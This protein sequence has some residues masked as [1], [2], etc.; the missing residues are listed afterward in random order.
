MSLSSSAAVLPKHQRINLMEDYTSLKCA[1]NQILNISGL[2][3][4]PT[5]ATN[6]GQRFVDPCLRTGRET[7]QDAFSGS[8]RGVGIH[9][10]P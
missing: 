8:S 1:Y 4:R 7:A 9:N 6:L 10:T 3:Q 2:K 5:E